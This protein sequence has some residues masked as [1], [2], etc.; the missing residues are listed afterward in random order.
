MTAFFSS[1]QVLLPCNKCNKVFRDTWFLQQHQQ[2]HSEVR[3]VLKCPR[4]GCERSFT[5]AFNLQNHIGSFH[6]E[7][8]P[9]TCPHA[10]CGKTFAMKVGKYTCCQKEDLT[11]ST[12]VNIA[13]M[14][15][16]VMH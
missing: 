3:Q 15:M 4:E 16:V 2:V 5:T 10:G 9:F 1:F 6:E 11:R 13:M 12:M 7:L 14:P 8:R